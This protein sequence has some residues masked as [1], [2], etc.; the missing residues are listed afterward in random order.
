[1]PP[2][3]SA[4]SHLGRHALL[5]AGLTPGRDV[6]IDYRK[7][8]DSCLQQVQRGEAV[9][10]I[11]ALH[12][13][14]MLPKEMSQG[15]RTVGHTEKI[16]GVVFMA[17]KRLPKKMHKQLRAEIIAW[18]DSESGRKILLSM[19]LGDFISINPADYQ[20]ISVP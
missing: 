17:H 14:A 6:T 3:N 9:A 2:E 4:Q 11:T 16:P 7:T 10:C 19:G 12:T 1:M 13:L 18:K 15:L 20:H 5:Q 8:H